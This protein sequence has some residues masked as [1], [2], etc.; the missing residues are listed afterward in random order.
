MFLLLYVGDMLMASKSKE[1]IK[2]VKASLKKEFDIKDLGESSKIL[3]IE[4]NRRR[5]ENLLSIS[6]SSYCYKAQHI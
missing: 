5:K 3:G 6:Q 2:A 1:D 4:I